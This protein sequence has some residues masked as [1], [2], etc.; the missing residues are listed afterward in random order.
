MSCLPFHTL[1]THNLTS[2]QYYYGISNKEY[3]IHPIES[4]PSIA[5]YIHCY[6]CI[7]DDCSQYDTIVIEDCSHCSFQLG[8]IKNIVIVRNCQD[9]TLS[10]CSK[11]LF[12]EYAHFCY[13]HI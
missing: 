3:S 7:I 12:M 5:Y 13:L 10:T 6:D 2:F 9:I 4:T 11:R 8:I 1:I